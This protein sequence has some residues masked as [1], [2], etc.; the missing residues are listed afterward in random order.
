MK[1]FNIDLWQTLKQIYADYP[2]SYL[3]DNFY[4]GIAPEDTPS[5]YCV[6][7][8]LDSGIDESSQTL[9]QK[10]EDYNTVGISNIQFSLYAINDMVIDE[11]LQDLND[12]I[13]GLSNLEEYRILKAVR[14]TTKNASSFT[15][16]VGIGL[17]RFEFQYEKL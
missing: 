2:D 7:H 4:F 1:T 5:N 6:I 8:V 3:G 10:N 9:C 14:Q 16:E 12:T 15:N 11:L 17:T 13:E